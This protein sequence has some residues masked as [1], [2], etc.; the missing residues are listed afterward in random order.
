MPFAI[1]TSTDYGKRVQKHLSEDQIVWLTTTRADGTP[2][3]A[4]VWFLWENGTALIFTEPGAHKVRNIERQP[5]V[6]LN[7]DGDGR[8]GDIVVLIGS[9][10]IETAPVSADRLA[11]Y[12]AKYRDGI[13]MIGLDPDTMFQK[14]STALRFT[15]ERVIGH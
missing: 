14:Y 10:A 9:M 15:P 6:A 1:D 5:R 11:N 2:L 4:P 3:P 8:G 13:K 12:V 7:F